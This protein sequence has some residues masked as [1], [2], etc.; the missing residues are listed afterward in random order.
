MIR[1]EHRAITAGP[2]A[3]DEHGTKNRDI[4]ALE[5]QGFRLVNAIP[6]GFPNSAALTWR[7][8]FVREMHEPD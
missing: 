6:T 5:R 4:Q 2:G 7:F 1:Y 3:I 8:F